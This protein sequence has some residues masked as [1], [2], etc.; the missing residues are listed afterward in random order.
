MADAPDKSVAPG[1]WLSLTLDH[2]MP[3]VSDQA[4]EKFLS[5]PNLVGK[6]R[7]DKLESRLQWV[8]TEE[9]AEC[10][11]QP[12]SRKQLEAYLRKFTQKS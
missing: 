10:K 9:P 2:C 8:T 7:G 3:K 6:W 11:G 12:A 1:F 4:R 5:N